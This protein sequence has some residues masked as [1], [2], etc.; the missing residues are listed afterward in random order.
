MREL[1]K[2]NP[3]KLIFIFT[4][5]LLIGNIFQQFYNMVDMIIVGQTLGKNALAAVG[6]TGSLT[7]LIIGFAQGLTAGLAIITAQRFGAQ[8]YRGLKKSFATSI[9]ISLVVTIILTVLSL[10]FIRPMLQLMQTPPEI[11][12][13]AQA[14]ISIILMGIFASMSF[15][16]L[17]NVI[18][19][20]GDSRTPLFFL[21]IAVI[22]NVILDLVFIIHFGMDVEG[23][24]IATV[25]AQV[26]SSL[27]CLIYI[28]RKIPLLQLRKKDFV[29][30]K[31]EIRTHLNI[32]L[33]MAFQASIIAIG[34]IILQSALNSLGTDVV[35][36]QAAA[37]RIDQ[38]A[39][40]PMMS[41][42]ITM[43][44]FTAQNYGA[45][46][47]GRILKGVKQCLLMSG[48][49]SIIAGAV[50]I[51]FG[52]SFVHLFVDA[53]ETRVFELAQIYFNINGSLYWIL[54][55]LF[56]LRYTLQGL[57]QSKIPTI[58]GIM[59]LIMRSFAAIFLT[60]L[61]GYPGAA[62][63]SPLAWIGSVAVLLYSYFKAIK[64]LRKLDEQQQLERTLEA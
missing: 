40:Q 42:G 36:A 7:F 47:Y 10:L 1:T 50:V 52:H 38:F 56:I 8:D 18:R 4:I 5:P 45:K 14:F 27:L 13:Q 54:A 48:G 33:P 24:G 22:I 60:A 23:A 46:E 20:L 49:F 6:S 19:A 41:F 16:L 37:G 64:K 2:G 28:K 31:K 25:I 21:I 57:G 15:N 43:A 29:F 12:D 30:D 59:E 32:S 58:A 61:W 35:A 9:I 53:S 11:I 34:A 17:S 63:A 39:T 55:I 62:A 26:A 51:I 44:T 3:A